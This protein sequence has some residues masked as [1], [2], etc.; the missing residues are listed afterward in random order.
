MNTRKSPPRVQLA[1]LPTPIQPMQRLSAHLGGPQL[2]IKRDD[3]TGLA[4]GGNKARKLEFL[5]A[6]A[7]AHGAKTLI[8]AGAAQSNHARQTAAAAAHF[9][10][11][12][13]LVLE[14]QA[15]S[16]P[17]GNLLL[18]HLLG[19]ELVWAGEQPT[20]A[21]LQSTFDQAWEAGRRPYLIPVGGSNAV[22]ASGYVDAMAELMEQSPDTQRVVVAS[23]SGG[24]LAGLLVGAALH[25]FSGMITAVRVGKYEQIEP[26]NLAIL[27]SETADLFG[28]QVDLA[29]VRYTLVEDYLGPGYGV[30]TDQEREAIR[31]FAQTEGV[32]LDPVYTGKAAAGLLDL[33]RRAEIGAGEK[34]LFWHTGGTPA[35]FAYA[36]ELL[37]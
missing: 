34:V 15:P 36:D 17:N 25:G 29:D 18:D 26:A 14:G 7:Q 2:W 16:R 30:L 19:A 9:G 12:C 13:I 33:V 4:G 24:T 32:L 20:V 27:A 10:F 1:L 11:D 8:T 23:S 3:Q 31:L 5:V 22:G 37:G 6:A 35:L 21:A 28:A